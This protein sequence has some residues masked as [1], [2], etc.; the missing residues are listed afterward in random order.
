[1]ERHAILDLMVKL[2]LRGMRAAFDEIITLAA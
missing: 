2:R 1:M